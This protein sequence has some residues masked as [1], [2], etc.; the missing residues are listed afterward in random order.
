VP[1]CSIPF[2]LLVLIGLVLYHVGRTTGWRR[3]VLLLLSFVFVTAQVD[4]L[5]A[6]VPLAAFI[7]LLLL[8]IHSVNYFKSRKLFIGCV[9]V[10]L[11][12]FVYLKRYAFV[13]FLPTLP[14]IHTTLGLSYILFRGLHVLIDTYQEEE[15][16]TDLDFV[17]LLIYLTS[18]LTFIAGPIQRY[19]E[20]REREKEW[21][22]K[23]RLDRA[24]V[25]QALLR[26]STGSLK[27]LMICPLLVRIDERAYER[28]TL[29][30]EWFAV[31]A[32]AHMLV[33]YLN[34]S[35]YM[36]VVIGVGVLFGQ[37]LPENFQSPL[38]A[39]NFLELWTRWHITLSDWFKTYVF[40]PIMQFF[41]QHCSRQEVLPYF[42]VAA[43]FIV[44]FL[45][46]VWHGASARY[47]VLGLVL[48]IGVSVNKLYEVEMIRRLGKARFQKLREFP[49]YETIA[50][51]VMLT[52]FSFAAVLSWERMTGLAWLRDM[53]G[54]LGGG[55][56]S[57]IG[58]CFLGFVAAELS[59]RLAL[60][61]WTRIT[62]LWP[63]AYR[64]TAWWH[65][66]TSFQICLVS[67][68]L[69]GVWKQSVSVAA[70]SDNKSQPAAAPI[71][72]TQ[73]FYGKH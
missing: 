17:T 18:F 20:Y 34:F 64:S 28:M 50:R 55:V 30:P 36:D 9:A 1:L 13:E 68:F 51:A 71:T 4:T 40:N 58:L 29:R 63:V 66:A 31:A 14:L 44:F 43:Y 45:L 62:R 38:L 60:A 24:A 11:V 53:L 39:R 67:V 49:G 25:N 65:L 57:S 41:C 7:G 48:G 32:V 5:T 70:T 69:Y 42:G 8:C 2:A 10:I 26:I 52:F 16:R 47:L 61:T 6:L 56:V 23:P 22:E 27:I 3:F 21:D 72:S 59:V 35:G 54:G 46:G 73:I 12:S 19:D 33:L 37:K 15:R